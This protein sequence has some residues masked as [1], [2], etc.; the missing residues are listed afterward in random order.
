[1]ATRGEEQ[2]HHPIELGGRQLVA[3]QC[4]QHVDLVAGRQPHQRPRGGGRQ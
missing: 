3:V 1:M 2:I 4:R